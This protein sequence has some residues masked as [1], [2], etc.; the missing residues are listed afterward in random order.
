MD[1]CVIGLGEIGFEVL[2]ELDKKIKVYGCDINH[3]RLDYL[4]TNGYDVG[5]DIRKSDIYI[6]AVYTSNQIFDALNKI[7]F[8]NNPLVVIESTV[9]PNR[10]E[11][12]VDFSKSKNFDL[13]FFPHRYNPNDPEH[14]VFNLNRIIGGVTDKANKRALNFYKPFLNPDLVRIVPYKI[15]A[16]AKVVENSYRFMEIV[17][18]QNLKECSKKLGIDFEELRNA[19]NTKWNIDVR[20]ARDGV[21]GKCLPKDI[22]LLANYFD[23]SFIDN[24][25]KSNENYKK[26]FKK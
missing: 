15:A 18:A 1:V 14:H 3:E 12:L 22:Q 24:F 4:K 26:S 5:F 13:V 21:G 17:I 23:S 6:N 2:K 25:I 19:C 7:E 8:D 16:I 9:A 11:E 10:L 20:E